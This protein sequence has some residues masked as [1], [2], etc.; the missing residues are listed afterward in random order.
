VNNN[1]PSKF[2]ILNRFQA[3]HAEISTRLWYE[4]EYSVRYNFID[5]ERFH[6]CSEYAD[7]P[8]TAF[9]LPPACRFWQKGRKSTNDIIDIWLRLS[10][11][12]K[13]IRAE[14]R[15]FLRQPVY[16]WAQT[17]IL[18]VV[19]LSQGARTSGHYP[20]KLTSSS[21]FRP[22]GYL[23]FN[24]ESFSPPARLQPCNASCESMMR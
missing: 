16:S 7:F 9:K 23:V 14:S 24:R 12:K 6:L 11:P 21:S 1:W 3:S 8:W 19:S 20:P 22:T 4:E 18:F 5:L 2:R 17:L 10:S 15:L 13:S